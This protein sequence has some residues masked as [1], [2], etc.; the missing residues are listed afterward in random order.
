MSVKTPFM[1]FFILVIALLTLNSCSFTIATLFQRPKTVTVENFEEL[2]EGEQKHKIFISTEDR[3]LFTE[4]STNKIIIPNK[5]TSVIVKV[6]KEGYQDFYYRI[7]KSGDIVGILDLAIGA[8]ATAASFILVND[9]QTRFLPLVGASFFLFSGVSSFF[10]KRAWG[11]VPKKL[12]IKQTDFTE[13]F[14]HQE[15]QSQIALQGIS[16]DTEGA[17]V[18]GSIQLTHLWKYDFLYD[19]PFYNQAN[20]ILNNA[21]LNYKSN[22]LKGNNVI[23]LKAKIKDFVFISGQTKGATEK[24]EN[25]KISANVEW[26]LINR[27]ND[28]LI[29]KITVDITSYDFPI[30][31]A[32]NKEYA[33]TMMYDALD[34]LLKD[35]KFITHLEKDVYAPKLQNTLTLEQSKKTTNL[36]NAFSSSVVVRSGKVQRGGFVIADDGYIIS[37]SDFVGAEDIEIIYGNYNV[38]KAEIIN[39]NFDANI[40]LLKAKE[41][42]EDFPTYSIGLGDFKSNLG[43]DIFIITS[44][45][46]DGKF[47]QST[48]SGILAGFRKE[49]EV[50]LLQT[51]AAINYGARGGPAIN[52]KGEL[53]GLVSG[54]FGDFG[55]EGLG[56]IVDVETVKKMLNI[57]FLNN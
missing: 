12:S 14:T 13:H 50:Q 39:H 42:K 51:D 23:V 49:K 16:V 19:F 37:T 48:S 22:P 40:T 21:N 34:K 20:K 33:Y 45:Y 32:Y 57:S 25:Y 15:N 55:E 36:K 5:N 1:P 27:F 44:K 52:A 54:K 26:S 31:N 10:V 53:V 47:H 18:K 43:D 9:P 56:F 41:I 46:E 35:E 4:L 24:I 29:D 7:E 2:T 30:D 11:V 38:V 3:P 6:R 28:E 8:G 17:K